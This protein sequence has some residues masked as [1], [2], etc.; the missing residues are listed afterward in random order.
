[1]RVKI[2]TKVHYPYFPLTTSTVAEA[3]KW[4]WWPLHTYCLLPTLSWRPELCPTFACQCCRECSTSCRSR[5]SLASAVARLM[6]VHTCSKRKVASFALCLTDFTASR[7]VVLMS[8]TKDS[9]QRLFQDGD[10][11]ICLV[12]RIRLFLYKNGLSCFF[13]FQ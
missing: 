5:A 4:T 3:T 1:M 13:F 12:V 9:F 7:H 10:W 2:T 11:L 8:W 6:L